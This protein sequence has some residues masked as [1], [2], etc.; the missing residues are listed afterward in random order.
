ME[1]RKNLLHGVNFMG[2]DELAFIAKYSNGRWRILGLKK[3]YCVPITCHALHYSDTCFEGTNV[4]LTAS[5]KPVLF[6]IK[7]N[8]NRFLRSLD[9]LAMPAIPE[10]IFIGGIQEIVSVCKKQIP[11]E[12]NGSLYVRPFQF[13][14]G[15]GAG[16]YGNSE[17]TFAVLVSPLFVDPSKL[18]QVALEY[19]YIHAAEGGTGDVKAGGNYSPSLV[20]DHRNGS[21]M[22]I[23]WYNKATDAIQEVTTMNIFF[24]LHDGSIIT[25][26]LD[27]TIL[28]GITRD[29]V[30]ELIRRN[31]IPLI[32]RPILVSELEEGIETG[33]FVGMFGTGSASVIVTYDEITLRSG[34][35][36]FN[37]NHVGV[38]HI[39]PLLYKQL[40]ES[41]R[42]EN[43]K[44]TTLVACN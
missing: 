1:L 20:V 33:K 41:F 3:N 21:D 39:I 15:N 14:S 28:P 5:G 8:Y 17:F 23:L 38:A 6:R 27:G 18:G 36:T 9:R 35:F 37:H 26:Q 22:Q 13:G 29:T 24:L 42:E 2:W 10:E 34:K 25:P 19:K 44:W 4:R 11:T 31:N 30:M 40:Q 7:D 32:E 16:V 12:Y 43:G